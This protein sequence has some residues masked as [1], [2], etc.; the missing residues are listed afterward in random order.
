V[1]VDIADGVTMTFV[2]VPPGE[3]CMGSPE[4][5]DHIKDEALHTVILTEP[6]DLAKYEVT[7]AQ[8]AVVARAAIHSLKGKD[9][10]PSQFKGTD[11]PVE[12]V[13]LEEADAFGEELT[14]VRKDNHV[15]R[16][17]RESE[18]EYSC[19][20]GRPSSQAFGIG[21][22]NALSST[23]ANF[24][25]A[26]PHGGAARGPYLGMTSPVGFYGYPNSLGLYD[27][28]GNV[29]EWCADR[30]GPYPNREVTN[31]LGPNDP[32]EF[33]YRVVRGG[34]WR[35]GARYCGAAVRFWIAPGYRNNY[36]GFRLA[37][38][39]PSAGK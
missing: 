12:S 8:Y 26:Y 5:E 28:H 31:P 19:R 22:G 36:L 18:W 14:L 17:P 10:D 30:Y 20:G 11:L 27:M 4:G 13:S 3:F 29:W 21:A 34:C 16:L 2:L 35:S 33:P 32:K 38:S 37:R 23:E 9:K 6:F 15:Y 7:Q 25:G 1:T 24:D 39:I